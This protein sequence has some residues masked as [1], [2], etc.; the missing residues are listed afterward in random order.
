MTSSDAVLMCSYCSRRASLFV[1][2]FFQAEDGIRDKLVT[3]VQTCALPISA[4]PGSAV[5]TPEP[6]RSRAPG[7]RRV[8]PPR[9]S[10]CS[11][12]GNIL[13]QCQQSC[14]TVAAMPYTTR[15]QSHVVFLFKAE[16]YYET[17]SG[18]GR[19]GAGVTIRASI[20]GVS[21]YGAAER[22]RRPA[23]HPQCG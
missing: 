3:G 20:F 17:A 10:A 6:A 15:S 4:P 16:N 12:A 23:G 5:P 11:W 18:G 9:S 13:Q 1:F 8:G 22:A 21:G 14:P 19:G 7:H 2:F